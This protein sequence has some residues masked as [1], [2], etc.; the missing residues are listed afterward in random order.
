MCAHELCVQQLTQELTVAR[1]DIDKLER[2]C[3]DYEAEI[4]KLKATIKQLEAQVASLTQE[5]DAQRREIGVLNDEVH[6]MQSLV[7]KLTHEKKVQASAS[8][9]AL[10]S[11]GLCSGGDKQ[12]THRKP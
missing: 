8:G 2:K 10:L 6:R 7:A 11:M 12:A 9:Y 4:A 1:Q 3:R 5:R